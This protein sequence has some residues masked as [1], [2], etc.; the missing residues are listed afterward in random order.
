MTK[1]LTAGKPLPLITSFMLPMLFGN[2]FQQTYNL[3]D[4]AI[5]GRFLGEDALAAV[6][7]SSSV[8]FLIL[9]FCMGFCT[10]FSVP[11]AQRFGAKDY[12]SMKKYIYHAALLAV[13]GAIIITAGCS[14]FC[15]SIIRLLS[16]PD[17]IFANAYTYLLIIFLGIPFTILYNLT[18]GILRAVG[19]S[20]NPFIFLVISTCINICL[21]LVFIIV[22]KW[23]VA[24]AAI[25]TITAQ[26]MS[27]VM[28]LVYIIK[29][30]PLLHVNSESRALSGKYVKNLLVMGIPM[31]L[32]FSITAIGSMVMQSVNN[33]LGTVYITGLTAGT[34]IKQF[35]LCPY[36]ALSTAAATYCSQNLGA[37]KMSRIREGIKTSLVIAVIYGAAVGAAL[38]FAG[39]KIA[40][41]F[42]SKSAAAE[43]SAAAAHMRAMGYFFWV[44]GIL[45]VTRQIAQ[46]LG[47]AGRAVFAGVLEMVARCIVCLGFAGTYGYAAICAADPS[48]WITACIYAVIMCALCVR[49]VSRTAPASRARG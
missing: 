49:K 13:A 37:G 20:K 42:I 29:K 1:D 7:A 16:T 18:A 2:L 26:G 23:G 5:V 14:I 25:A 27:G 22:F 10:G 28:C 41:L 21:D 12:A 34:K 43:I 4:T 19:D 31:G 32:Q 15:A 44:L 36:D 3:A 45:C 40:L 47:F 46:G 35:L 17:E 11:V 38:V 33:A 8:Q 48:A 24:G 6:G 39:D 30:A 9:G